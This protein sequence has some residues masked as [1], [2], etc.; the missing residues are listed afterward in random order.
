MPEKN[1]V[2]TQSEAANGTG[3]EGSKVPSM[4]SPSK[5]V[6]SEY[7]VSFS[8]GV[9]NKEGRLMQPIT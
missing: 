2:T 4:N 8:A 7:L 6:E 9:L 5:E 3:P 1:T